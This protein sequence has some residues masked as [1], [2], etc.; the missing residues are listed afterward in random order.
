MDAFAETAYRVRGGRAVGRKSKEDTSQL[1]RKR[2][3]DIL[4][5]SAHTRPW[6]VRK[7]GQESAGHLVQDLLRP[8]LPPPQ[9]VWEEVQ[10]RPPTPLVPVAPPRSSCHVPQSRPISARCAEA[11]DSN[12]GAVGS[13][14]TELSR[15][16]R[17][18]RAD[19]GA[20]HRGPR[21]I[22]GHQAGE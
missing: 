19:H 6:R 13:L 20:P 9:A 2:G 17:P 16:Q 4:L 7:V 21:A 12:C 8:Q 14:R 10:A 11:R 5:R 22:P 18:L 15:P 3:G 1:R